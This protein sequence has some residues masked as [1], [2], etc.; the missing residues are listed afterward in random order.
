[1]FD[2]D[3]QVVRARYLEQVQ[4]RM[5]GTVGRSANQPFVTEDVAVA[6][7]D[8]RLEQRGELPLGQDFIQARQQHGVSAF[9]RL[10]RWVGLVVCRRCAQLQF[11]D[12]VGGR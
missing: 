3:S 1:M 6:H 7:A 12:A 5:Q 8:D 2:L 10:H 11:D 4:R 9:W